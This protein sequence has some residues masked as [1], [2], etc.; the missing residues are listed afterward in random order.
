[1]GRSDKIEK[2]TSTIFSNHQIDEFTLEQMSDD[3]SIL[4][5]ERRS[6]LVESSILELPDGKKSY[7]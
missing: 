4:I 7:P 6:Q 2:L 1:M 5:I 3:L